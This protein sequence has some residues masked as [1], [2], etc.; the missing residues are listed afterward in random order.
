MSV[1]FA[2]FFVCCFRSEVKIL[3]GE[4]QEIL[5]DLRLAESDSNQ[6]KDAKNTDTLTDL[7]DTQGQF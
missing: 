1:S 7:N 4:K 3:E 5:K 6:N 2:D